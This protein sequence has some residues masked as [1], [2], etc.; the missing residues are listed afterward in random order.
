MTKKNI[1]IFGATGSIGRSIVSFL[2]NN[3]DVV[4]VVRSVSDE[5]EVH[6]NVTSVVWDVLNHDVL[7]QK[8]KNQKIDAICWAQGVNMNDSI[9]DFDI[10]KHQNMYNVNCLLILKSLNLLLKNNNINHS[11]KMCILSSIWQNIARQNKISYCV[12]KAAIMG[13]VNSLAIDLASKNCLVNAILPG[14][15]ETSMTYANLSQNQIESVKSATCHG[16]LASLNDIAELVSF[17]CGNANNS[18]TGQC[19]NIDLGFSNARII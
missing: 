18:I 14:V 11:A 1:L 17:L 9:Y 16:R 15:T 7:P 10:L 12:T 19:I 3:F 8:I 4:A 13:V 5:I 6:E 2:K